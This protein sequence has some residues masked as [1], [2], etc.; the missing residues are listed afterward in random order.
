MDT[1]ELQPSSFLEKIENAISGFSSTHH[2]RAPRSHIPPNLLRAKYAFVREDA[3][4]PPLTPLYRG[5][6]LV[7][8]PGDKF[9]KLQIGTKIDT[10]SINKL[11]PLFYTDLV[12]VAQ[13][14]SSTINQICSLV[15]LFNQI[16]DLF[17]GKPLQPDTR[18]VP[19]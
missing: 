4:S 5:P 12:S 7:I 1:S 11:K 3:T 19:R 6:Y 9:F 8:E 10:V 17:L 15:N 13:P 14:P 18:S 2:H 16:P